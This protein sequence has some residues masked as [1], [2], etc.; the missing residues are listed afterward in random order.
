MEIPMAREFDLRR[1]LNG[2]SDVVAN[3]PPPLREFDQIYMKVA[4]M[5]IQAHY[6]ADRFHDRSVVF[7]GDGDAIALTVMHLASQGIFE[8]SPKRIHVLDFDERI[9][10]SI[11]RFSEKHEFSERIATTL[12]NVADALPDTFVGTYDAFYTNPP[13]GASNNGESV[14]AFLERGIEACGTPA[15][16]VIVIADDRERAWTQQVLLESQ[17]RA[18]QLGFVVAEL[19]PEMHAYHLDDSPELRSCSCLFRRVE[20]PTAEPS[21]AMDPVRRENFY[22]RNN[23]LRVHYVREQTT[24][25]YGKAVDGTYRLEPIT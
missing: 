24:L 11:L 10:N 23:P 8:K 13:W 20:S 14:C 1:A 7:V 21:K 18:A 16:G 9:V 2:V 6:I 5:V 19:I 15:E 3:R 12:Y 4:D 25:N 17:R 22:G